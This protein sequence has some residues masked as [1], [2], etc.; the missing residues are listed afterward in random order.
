[1]G[2]LEKELFLNL[3]DAKHVVRVLVRLAVAIV[4]GAVI[5]TERQREHKQAGA[6]THMLVALGAALFTLV[7]LEAG[8][9][10]SDLSRII[11]GVATGVGF[12]GAG[13]ILKLSDT[14]EVKGLTTA[15]SIWLTAAAGMA[16]GAGWI[17]PAVI[18]V[19]LAWTILS[20]L[21]TL[22]RW[23]KRHGYGGE[24]KD[25]VSGNSPSPT[26]KKRANLNDA[27]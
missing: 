14:R 17:W 9:K 3:P 24:S 5:G 22:E 20:V 13:T 1:V 16:A 7:P 23:L 6:R 8:M 4:L 12:L 2:D 25:R 11:Q 10:V 19:A 26:G 18:G 21:H 27:D 15:A